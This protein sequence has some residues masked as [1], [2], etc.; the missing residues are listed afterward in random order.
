MYS[1]TMFSLVAP[2]LALLGLAVASS[3][4]SATRFSNTTMSNEANLASNCTLYTV[5][6]GD[7][8]L[9]IAWANNVSYAQLVTWNSDINAQCS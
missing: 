5:Q 9:S 4:S 8:C 2:C 1:G 6:S 7:T 3:A